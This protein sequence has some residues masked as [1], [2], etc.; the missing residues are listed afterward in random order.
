MRIILKEPSDKCKTVAV[1]GD[2]NVQEQWEK[3][4]TYRKP[5]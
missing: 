3:P 4:V 2:G 1:G 5:R